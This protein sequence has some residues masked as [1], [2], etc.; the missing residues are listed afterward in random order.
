MALLKRITVL[1]LS[2]AIF[3]CAV[4]AVSAKEDKI[5]FYEDF[6]GYATNEVN[7]AVSIENTSAY[8]KEYAK[9]D[10]AISVNAGV[11]KGKL[12]ASWKDGSDTCVMAFDLMYEDAAS[13]VS[14]LVADEKGVES[15]LLSFSEQGEIK[16]YDGKR[17]GNFSMGKIVKLAVSIDSVNEEYSIYI[18][19]RCVLSGW[20]MPAQITPFGMTI[21]VSSGEKLDVPVYIDNIRAYSGNNAR[22]SFKKNAYNPETI[23]IVS[24]SSRVGAAVIANS[25]FNLPLG[26]APTVID[27]LRFNLKSN[28]SEIV[29]QGDN[30]YL[31][32][33]KITSN[34]FHIDTAFTNDLNYLVLQS[35]FRFEKFGATID[36]F[37]LRDNVT[38]ATNADETFATIDKSGVLKL[39]NGENAY[40]FGLGKWY[41]IAIA[42]N[43]PKRVINVYIDNELVKENLPFKN[44][45]FCIPRMVRTWCHGTGKAAFCLDNYRIYEAVEPVLDLSELEGKSISVMSDGEREQALLEGKTAICLGSGVIYTNGK[46]ELADTPKEKDGD[47]YVSKETAQKLLGNVDAKYGDNVPLKAQAASNGLYVYENAEKYLLIFANKRFIADDALINETATYMKMLMPSA[48]TIKADFTARNEQHPRILATASDWERIRNNIKTDSEFAT[49]HKKVMGQADTKLNTPVEYYH[50]ESQENL[51]Q[52]ARRFKEKMIYWGYAWKVTGDRKYVD[53]AWEE[54]K[55]VCSF[56]DWSPVHPIDT[57]EMLF[58]SAIGYD[59]MYDAL[60]QEQRKTIEEGTLRLGIEVLR[61]AYYGQLHIDMKYGALSGGNFVTSD[62]NFNVVVNGGLTAAAMAYADVY[63]DECFDAASK[64][65]QSLGYMLPGFEPSGGWKEGP[66]YWDYAT[67]YLANMVSALDTACGTDYGIMR[68]PGV[69][70]TPY[71]AIYL[72]SPQGLNNFSDTARGVTWNSPQFSCFAKVMNEPSFTYQRYK[73]ITE[74]NKAPTVFDMI[75]LDISQK[76]VKPELPLDNFTPEIEMV[77]IREDWEKTDA[78]NFGVHGGKNNVYH[79][80]YDGGTWIFDILGERWALDLGMDHQSYVGYTM[81]NLYRCRAEGHNMLVFN[82]SKDIDFVKQSY[83]RL[84][85]FET[86]PKGAIVVY[87]NS[88]GYRNWTTNVTRGFYIGDERRSLTVRDEFSVK[89]NDTIVY[90]N[91]Q[92]PADI[93]IDGNKA[94]LT[95][96]DKKLCVEFATDAEDFEVL[97]LKAEPLPGSIENDYMTKDPGINKLALRAKVSKSAYI[98]AKLYV[99][100]EPS[101]KSGMINKPISEWTLPEGELIRRGNSMLSS[102]TVDGKT[103]KEFKPNTTTYN[104]AVLEGEKIPVIGATSDSGLFDIHQATSTDD[105]TTITAYDESGLYTTTYVIKYVLL[106]APQDVFG[107]TRNIVYGLEVSSTPEE[108]NVGPNMLDGDLGTR[109]AGQGIGEWAVFDLGSSK[110]VDAIGIAYEW[111]DKRKYSFSVE[112]SEDGDYYTEVYNGASS[113]T[114]EDM[115]LVKL[116]KRVNA[117]YVRFVGGG[118]T[119]NTWNGVREFAIL[120]QKGAK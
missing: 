16:T 24:Q 29:S 76:N 35:D 32:M 50:Y 5:Y 72:D 19:D 118:N 44:A 58:G 1:V 102:I 62:T 55:A 42:L 60:T 31:R 37:I 81:E 107:M 39:S 116:N 105:V 2:C 22:K 57:G 56:P 109:W 46:K 6:N 68:H 14:L 73:A 12:K 87:D 15:A 117:R 93:E 28:L 79:G 91:M 54:I 61:S 90:W 78:M 40:T 77:S 23:D 38:N 75:W 45:S 66:N 111:G 43:L 82:P 114:T 11:S 59:W 95:I 8:V 41:N 51:L 63:P 30:S 98:E 101:S 69:N 21:S 120:T 18:N 80:H 83:T 52:V 71:Y 99:P 89:S 53:R 10:K 33:E 106:K 100:G 103:L 26:D 113:G 115:E 9:Q 4:P 36:P 110:P 119:V 88:E 25:K 96:N 48:D 17:V 3:V 86:A 84:K 70:L 97:A 20:D 94:I 27:A 74:K 104:I 47:Y 7:T 108:A 92:T 67:A 112:V 49:W 64:A 65:I 34:D 85:R 13:I